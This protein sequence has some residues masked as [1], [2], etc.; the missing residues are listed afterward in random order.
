MTKT[1]TTESAFKNAVSGLSLNL[2]T[3]HIVEDTERGRVRCFM[4]RSG[5]DSMRSHHRAASFRFRVGVKVPV[6]SPAAV[7]AAE[8]W[9]GHAV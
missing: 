2:M 7:E 3:V 4:T 9:I 8:R 1:L 5:L 6:D